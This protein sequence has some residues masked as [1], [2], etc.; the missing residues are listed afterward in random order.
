[1]PK[2]WFYYY[3]TSI[4]SV[5]KGDQKLVDLKYLKVDLIDCL[6]LFWIVLYATTDAGRRMI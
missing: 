5:L 4:W 1:M 3:N 2:F 6:E